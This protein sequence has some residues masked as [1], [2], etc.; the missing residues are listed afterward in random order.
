M[1]PTQ[2]IDVL[3][4]IGERE[5][6]GLVMTRQTLLRFEWNKLIPESQRGSKGRGAGRWTEYPAETIPQAYAAWSLLHGYY[7]GVTGKAFFGKPPKLSPNIIALVREVFFSRKEAM[8]GLDRETAITNRKLQEAMCKSNPKKSNFSDLEY[9]I[10]STEESSISSTFKYDYDAHK[11]QRA[12]DGAAQRVKNDVFDSLLN[13]AL[14]IENAAV[15]SIA[16]GEFDDLQM[17]KESIKI[18]I[19]TFG[20]LYGFQLKRGENWAKKISEQ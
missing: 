18:L 3:N 8:D 4:R 13:K 15:D 12:G 10:I 7:G 2:V 9:E 17:E 5:G 20:E 19:F 14:Q 1:N 11:N 6:S 16:H